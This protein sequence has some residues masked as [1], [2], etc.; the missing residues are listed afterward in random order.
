[1]FLKYV[2]RSLAIRRKQKVYADKI[3]EGQERIRVL[4]K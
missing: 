2:K 3:K 4:E 1:M